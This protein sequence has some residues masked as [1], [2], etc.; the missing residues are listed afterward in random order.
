MCR[1]ARRGGRSPASGQLSRG[2]RHEPASAGSRAQA[3]RAALP[4]APTP[5]TATPTPLRAPPPCAPFRCRIRRPGPPGPGPRTTWH[6]AHSRCRAARSARRPGAAPKAPAGGP[7]RA[8]WPEARAAGLWTRSS[9]YF[10]PRVEA[11][12]R[13]RDADSD[14]SQ[15]RGLTQAIETVQVRR[16]VAVAGPPLGPASG[17]LTTQRE[18]MDATRNGVLVSCP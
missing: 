8:T 3:L 13:R 16:S 6:E 4:R 7:G 9:G 12:G 17:C 15:V 14:L 5:L 2:E 1:T 11:D 18:G 10:S